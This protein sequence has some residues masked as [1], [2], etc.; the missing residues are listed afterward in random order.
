MSDA[1]KKLLEEANQQGITDITGED[2][3]KHLVGEGNKYATAEDLAK[4]ALSGQLHISKIEQENAAL[5]E[6]STAAKGVDDILAALKGQI[7][8]TTEDGN[9]QSADQQNQ[10]GSD[11][12]SVS[13]QI[14]AAFAQRDQNSIAQK[15]EANIA[16]TV[17]TLAKMYGDKATEVYEQVGND[18]GI[19][20]ED[21]AKK[22]PAAVIKLV[23]DA[24][25]ASNTNSGLQQS[26]QNFT[27]TQVPAGAMNKSAID[28]M[29]K[30]G[31]L[32]RY[33]KIDLE[34][35]MLTQLGDKFFN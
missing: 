33:E 8:A 20:L 28:Q 14:A 18:L 6:S 2:A 21:L 31:K 11:E 4:A 3:L 5:R 13:D 29:F 19:S 7:T 22:S 23:A 15:E 34:N 1:I 25:P 17:N 12:V 9:H 16:E 30:D 10:G 32:T 26:T 24:R 27:Q 35:K